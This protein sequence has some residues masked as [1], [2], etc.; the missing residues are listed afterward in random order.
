M[1]IKQR[2]DKLYARSE[3]SK[4]LRD[5]MNYLGKK[6]Q[7]ISYLDLPLT[8]YVSALMQKYN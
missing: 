1:K 4:F 8:E 2:E 3:D 5:V 7:T 6:D